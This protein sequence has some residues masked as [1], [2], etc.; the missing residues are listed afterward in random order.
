MV[1]WEEVEERGVGNNGMKCGRMKYQSNFCNAS[2]LPWRK[3]QLYL[4][5]IFKILYSAN[6]DTLLVCKIIII[7]F[8]IV[9]SPDEFSMLIHIQV[10]NIYIP[11]T[12]AD[13]YYI[14]I[15]TIT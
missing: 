4:T 7:K 5:V 13:I 2:K 11:F 3:F 6:D 15:H 9:L 10:H 14:Y 8:S 12:F 1:L